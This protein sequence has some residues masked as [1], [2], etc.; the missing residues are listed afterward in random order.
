MAI[1]YWTQVKDV[2]LEMYT[3]INNNDGSTVL[4]NSTTL[5]VFTPT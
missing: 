2:I 3:R 4:E 5:L 1:S